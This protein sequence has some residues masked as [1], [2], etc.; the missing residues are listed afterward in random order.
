MTDSDSDDQIAV[1]VTPAE[2]PL[3]NVTFCIKIRKR[4]LAILRAVAAAQGMN[5]S[6]FVREAIRDRINS[7]VVTGMVE[8]NAKAKSEIGNPPA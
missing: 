5:P 3:K 8:R 6:R 1:E 2:T 7:Y 4:D